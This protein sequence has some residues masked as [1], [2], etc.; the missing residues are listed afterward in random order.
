MKKRCQNLIDTLDL[1]EPFDIGGFCR[2]LAETRGRPLRLIALDLPHGFPC[3]MWLNTAHADYVFHERNTSPAHRAH[4]VV[5]ELGH[6]VFG[7]QGRSALGDTFSEL[8]LPD[9]APDMIRRMLG[10]ALYNSVEELEA[11][12]FASL[13]LRPGGAPASGS[14]PRAPAELAEAAQRISDSLGACGG[15]R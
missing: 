1:P 10:R 13:I 4:I 7:H 15:R 9:L 12:T 5:H 11:E 2:R 14:A 3:G 8:L 6:M